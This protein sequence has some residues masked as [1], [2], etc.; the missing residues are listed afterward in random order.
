L[1]WSETW[2]LTE[3]YTASE[4]RSGCSQQLSKEGGGGIIISTNNAD[5]HDLDNPCRRGVH[6]LGQ[7]PTIPIHPFSLSTFTTT[8]ES[9]LWLAFRL[10]S[11]VL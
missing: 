5:L 11:I 4:G 2:T 3:L 7:S 8:V 6:L 9:H 10:A 1:Q